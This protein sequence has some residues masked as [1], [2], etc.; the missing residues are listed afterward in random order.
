M[1]PTRRLSFE[2]LDNVRD[3]GGLPLHA[4]GTT[5]SGVLLRSA[6]LRH[7]T[8]D[9]V[10]RLVEDLR[11]RLVLD[12]RTPGEID[13]DGPTP[14]A[15]AGVETVALTFVGASRE[16][17]PETGDD[18][19]P[20]LRNYLGYLGDHPANVI[21]AVRRLADL[22]DG[23]TLVHC[24]AGKDRT[25]VLVALV[26]DAVGVERDAVL[27]DYALSS[28]QIEAL[29]RRWTAAS[30]EPMPP[31]DELTRHHPRPEVM[32]SVLT[33]LDRTHG[34]GTSGGPAGWL[35]ANGLPASALD[36]LR[37]RLTDR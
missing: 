7:A 30:G 13:R 11:V 34:D 8:P 36:R 32:G 6:S 9:D 15:E 14:V 18:T 12:L 23:A 31:A 33:R 24:L 22:E 5:R 25:G 10:R 16:T 21:E 35:A 4:G 29:F 3:V 19:D 17:L 27:A 20:L 28:E 26:L 37:D 1:T 2:G